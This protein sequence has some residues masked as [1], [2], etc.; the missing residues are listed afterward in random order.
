MDSCWRCGRQLEHGT[1]CDPPCV[2]VTSSQAKPQ[3]VAVAP[4]I[5]VDWDKVLTL[6]D[7]KAVLREFGFNAI[8][9]SPAHERLR[10]FLKE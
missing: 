5:F 1:E 3:V 6:E 7:L 4:L 2:N 9:G 8:K 10:K